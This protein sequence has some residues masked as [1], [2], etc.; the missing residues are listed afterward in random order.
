MGPHPKR[1]ARVRLGNGGVLRAAQV[2]GNELLNG[3]LVCWGLRGSPGIVGAI[4]RAER[5]HPPFE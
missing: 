3:S 1:A 4:P 2:A 5:K